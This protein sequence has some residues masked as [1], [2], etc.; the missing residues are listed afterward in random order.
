MSLAMSSLSSETFEI[1]F[2]EFVARQMI[3]LEQLGTMEKKLICVFRYLQSKN[4]NDRKAIMLAE[5]LLK[6]SFDILK[7][8][9]FCEFVQT[10]KKMQEE[11]INK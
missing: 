11:K 7:S 5:K 8:N 2:N 9:G 3:K 1:E 4:E 6:S 10:I